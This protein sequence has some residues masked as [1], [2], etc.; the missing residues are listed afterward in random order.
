MSVPIYPWTP[1]FK[2]NNLYGDGHVVEY[3]DVFWDFLQN[4][5]S[6]EISAVGARLHNDVVESQNIQ[7][8]MRAELRDGIAND[9]LFT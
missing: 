8:V 2:M 1:L 4:G 9:K 5:I 3:F 6:I 7:L